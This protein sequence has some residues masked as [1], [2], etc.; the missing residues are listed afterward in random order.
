M[1]SFLE[2]LKERVKDIEELTF[3][4]T[5]LAKFRLDICHSCEHLFK[6]TGNCKKCGCFVAGKTKLKQQ[7]CPIDKW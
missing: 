4:D 7:K 1:P 2:K 5:E 6:P 3:A